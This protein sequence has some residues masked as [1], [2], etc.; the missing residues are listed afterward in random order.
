M[1]GLYS[2]THNRGSTYPRNFF[3]K[4]DWNNHIFFI[5]QMARQQRLDVASSCVNISQ[6]LFSRCWIKIQQFQIPFGHA[7]KA[8]QYVIQFFVILLK[9]IQTSLRP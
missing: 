7:G 8:I 9:Q 6:I 3:V 2:K 5:L 4:N 1:H